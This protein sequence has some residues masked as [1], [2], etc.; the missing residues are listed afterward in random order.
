[1]A[2]KATQKRRG[3]ELF[4]CAWLRTA[5]RPYQRRS[6]WQATAARGRALRSRAAQ[7]VRGPVRNTG[8]DWDA[9]SASAALESRAIED[10]GIERTKAERLASTIVDLIHAEVATTADVAAVSAELTATEAALR[11]DIVALSAELKAWR[12]WVIFQSAGGTET[13]RASAAV[14]WRPPG[15]STRSAVRRAALLAARAHAVIRIDELDAPA[16]CAAHA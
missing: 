11:A 2:E 3:S 5:A 6:V 12:C 15:R 9:S 1:M 4:G 7:S 13:R 14:D 10:A 8:R 16:D